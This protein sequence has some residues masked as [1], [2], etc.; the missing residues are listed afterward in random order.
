MPLSKKTAGSR[1]GAGSTGGA[2][3]FLL[4]GFV[5]LFTNFLLFSFAPFKEEAIDLR[6]LKEKKDGEK[7]GEHK[8]IYILHDLPNCARRA[9]RQERDGGEDLLPREGGSEESK[10]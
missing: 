9:T 5:C 8:H 2:F 10:L 7:R 1:G 6:T 4:L 3:L